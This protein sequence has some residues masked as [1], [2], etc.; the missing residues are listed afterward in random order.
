MKRGDPHSLVIFSKIAT[1]SSGSWLQC[2][3]HPWTC[4][5]LILSNLAKELTPGCW[6]TKHTFHLIFNERNACIW[7]AVYVRNREVISHL[8]GKFKKLSL[9]AAWKMKSSG[10]FKGF[11][12]ISCNLV[13][14]VCIFFF[15]KDS[16]TPL[17]YQFHYKTGGGLYTV[18][19]YGFEDHV[20]T[21]LP[22]GQKDNFA[23]EFSVTIRDKLFAE[24]T[25][26]LPIF[27]VSSVTL[28]I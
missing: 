4:I 7:S 14:I 17:T 6:F 25:V 12:L 27:R 22:Q 20:E 8:A 26:Q 3:P 11:P 15:L 2:R 23:F 9:I 21:V 28:G 24:T 19:S 10:K 16:E 1:C 18:V 5:S 13:I